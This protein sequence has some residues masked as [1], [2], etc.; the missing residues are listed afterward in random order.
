M[1][2]NKRRAAVILFL[3]GFTF[4]QVGRILGVTAA[5]VMDAVRR[6]GRRL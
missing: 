6:H 4:R 3:E 2:G 5:E 1:R